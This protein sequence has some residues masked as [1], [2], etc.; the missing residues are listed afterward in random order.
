M[1]G[2][3]LVAALA[4]WRLAA[5]G[6]P[7]PQVASWLVVLHGVLAVLGLGAFL[8]TTVQSAR[9]ALRQD[10]PA[11]VF[12]AAGATH[13]GRTPGMR[14][15]ASDPGRAPLLAAFPVLTAAL[16]LG[17]GWALLTYANPVLPVPAW[18]WLLAAWLLGAAYL[19]ATSGWRPLRL[20]AWLPVLLA[21]AGLAAG[22]AA[23]WNA[24][25]LFTM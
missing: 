21:G 16:L 1:A 2:G 23:A 8:V 24:P 13:G 15:R 10:S 19:H 6:L 20:P 9:F 5:A 18:L 3:A 25:S 22:L 17:S 7:G 4:A 12:D 11:D 14:G